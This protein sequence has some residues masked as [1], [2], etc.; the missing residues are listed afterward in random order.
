MYVCSLQ[1]CKQ[2]QNQINRPRLRQTKI[3][4]PR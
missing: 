3:T 2:D 1:L 4:R